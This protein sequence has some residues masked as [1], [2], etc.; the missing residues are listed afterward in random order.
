MDVAALLVLAIELRQLVDA[1]EAETT[2]SW[3]AEDGETP[4]CCGGRPRGE[5]PLFVGPCPLLAKALTVD[6][7]HI[8][9]SLSPA[10]AGP[11]LRR[12]RLQAG[13]SS[14]TTL[15]FAEA[16]ACR[17]VACE[18]NDADDADGAD[19]PACE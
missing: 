10:P 7:P 6:I 17:E 1:V 8:P 16:G 15:E 12:P 2:E 5:G 18:T 11:R 3:L 14:E 9:T 19:G 13:S 4:R